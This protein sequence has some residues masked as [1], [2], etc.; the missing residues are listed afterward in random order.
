MFNLANKIYGTGKGAYFKILCL[1]FKKW[2]L[3]TNC[4]YILLGSEDN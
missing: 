4:S 1:S 3:L 2:S